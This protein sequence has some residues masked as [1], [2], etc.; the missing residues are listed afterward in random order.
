MKILRLPPYPLSISYDVP[1]ASTPYDLIIEDEDRDIVILEERITS[2]AG[3]K[4]NYTFETDEWHLYDK[5]YELRIEEIDF[6][7]VTNRSLKSYNDATG[8]FTNI[9]P[10]VYNNENISSPFKIFKT[11]NDQFL[12]SISHQNFPVDTLFIENNTCLDGGHNF[13]CLFV[14][15]KNKNAN[16]KVEKSYKELSYNTNNSLHDLVFSVV[17]DS[18][19]ITVEYTFN[20]SIFNKK[21]IISIH[22]NFMRVFE[23]EN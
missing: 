13:P 23:Y 11:I 5:V 6:S 8:L 9:L 4:I 18:S 14:Y 16:F 2:T 1:A 21:N 7:S 22:N 10:F 17:E 12:E 19:D 20:K 15:H 3:K